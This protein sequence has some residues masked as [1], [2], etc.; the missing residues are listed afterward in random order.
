MTG[1][2]LVLRP[3]L[4]GHP[5][6]RRARTPLLQPVLLP[7]L[8]L[9]FGSGVASLASCYNALAMKRGR[10]AGY[11]LLA[12]AGGMLAFLLVASSAI[13]FGMVPAVAVILGRVV[14]FGFGGLMFS[15]QRPYVRGNEFLGGPVA[16]LLPSYGVA[17][18]IF[19]FLPA[20]LS[21]FLLG[22]PFAR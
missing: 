12:G 6:A 16:P 14:H 19:I 13:H 2:D 22:V 9:I 10:L 15:M 11:S 20:R 3:L 7:Y 8:A 17:V 21:L 18:G 1:G 4:S 5:D